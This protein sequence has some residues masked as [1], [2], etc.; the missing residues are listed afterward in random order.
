MGLSLGGSYGSTNQQAT[1]TSTTANTYSPTQTAL[2]SQIGGNL[3]TALTAANAGTLTPG[4]A[5]QKNKAAA[6][7]NT[8]SGGTIDRINQFLASRGFGKSGTAGKA[9]LTTELGR[10][11]A[12]AGNE[13]NF[14]GIQQG[15]NAQNLLAA[16]NYAFTSLGATAA[17]KSTGS[18]SGFGIAGGLGIPLTGG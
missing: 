11:S 6:D 12:L 18:T 14:A 13:A 1:G 9:A 2:Q 7:I 5:A 16:L 15:V 10:Q 8:T 17:G 4:V 3:S